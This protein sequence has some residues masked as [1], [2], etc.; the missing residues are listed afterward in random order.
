MVTKL[1]V[2][3]PAVRPVIFNAVPPVAIVNALLLL[4][5]VV[6]WVKFPPSRTSLPE[7]FN[8]LLAVVP[9]VLC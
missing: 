9:P 8:P 1:S 3:A 5:M 2:D 6:A 7:R 4:V